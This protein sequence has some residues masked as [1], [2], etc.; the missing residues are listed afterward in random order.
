MELMRALSDY[1]TPLKKLEL[2]GMP[3]GE[4]DVQVLCE[5]LA[6]DHMEELAID[7]ST[8]SIMGHHAETIRVKNLHV[9]PPMSVN[10]CT[11]L[12]SLLKHQI[13]QLKELDI[14]H[15]E[16]KSD[17]AVQL[18]AAL[19]KNKSVVKVNMGLNRD[20]ED[21]GAEAFGNMLRE[22]TVLRELDLSMC[23]VTSLGCNQLAEGVRV[24][25]TLQVLNLNNN[26]ITEIGVNRLLSS[27]RCNTALTRLILPRIYY[28]KPADP[29]VEWKGEDS[30]FTVLLL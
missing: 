25:S 18:A 9:S 1:K 23:V 4:E 7:G 16:I 5:V 13:C 22:N 24:N 2:K 19:S 21:V 8:I 20:I 11:S 6:D 15:C 27:L 14:F 30:V 26:P 10:D 29:R 17:G 12:A 3:L 28:E